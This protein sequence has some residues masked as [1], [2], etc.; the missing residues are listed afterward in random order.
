MSQTVAA[1]S[2][3]RTTEVLDATWLEAALQRVC[4]GI[5]VES[6]EVEQI[7]WGTSTKV[8]VRT[9]LRP[10][11][12]ATPPAELC[13]K[14][15]LDPRLA[16]TYKTLGVTPTAIE[17]I[18]YRDLAPALGVPTPRIWAAEAQAGEGGVLVMDNLAASGAT[19]GSPAASWSV[20]QVRGG[21]DTLAALH[22]KS[23]GKDFSSQTLLQVGSR[24]VREITQNMLF[25]E[26]NWQGVLDGP[27]GA[28]LPASLRERER[29]LAGYRSSYAINDAQAHSVGHGD[30]H[31]GNTYI[32]AQG[33]LLFLDWATICLQP[34]AADVAYF[35]VGSLT[36]EDR[37]HH[38]VELLRGYLDALA[39]HG[40]PALP[41]QAAWTL[42]RQSQLHGI[43]WATLPETMQARAGVLAMTQRFA[44]AIEDHDTL[45][46]L[47]C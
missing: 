39:R 14:G 36:V 13:I 41:F 12:R 22:G 43:I 15:E 1:V 28:E 3:P 8:L 30:A 40:G 44:S 42:Y 25:S 45:A 37:R 7:L 24:P 20:A 35:L 26:Q 46:A 16:D 34:W 9:E 2:I 19:F 18:F 38:E 17:A 27:V 10:G 47:G 23:W 32:T 4:P 6:M 29:I 21:L 5:G 31:I 33:Q 11:Q